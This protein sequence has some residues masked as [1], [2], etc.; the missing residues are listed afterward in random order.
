M[1]GRFELKKTNSGQ[2]MFNLKAGNGQIILTSEHY[3]QRTSAKNGIESARKS[4]A[5]DCRFERKT[6]RSGQPF[7]VLKAVNGQVVGRS[8]IYASGAAM[9]NGIRS[10]MTTV[11]GARVV[12]M[13]DR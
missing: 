1:T 8:E 6:A 13:S 2:Y 3:K 7:F 10:V 9:E 5:D 12:D 4:A 11:I